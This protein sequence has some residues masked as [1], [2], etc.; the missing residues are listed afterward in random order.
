MTSQQ[1]DNLS[2]IPSS[3]VGSED[4]DSA[5]FSSGDVQ[6]QVVEF[7][8]VPD[9]RYANG[10]DLKD[11]IELLYLVDDDIISGK[12][13]LHPWQVQF[14]LD[15]AD[16]R[17]TKDHPFAA[18]VCAAN[19]SGKDKYI[20]AVCIV[21]LCMRYTQAYGVATNGSGQQLDQQTEFHIRNFCEKVNTK[22]GFA[23]WKC[24]YRA[25]KCN[26]TKSQITLFATD[27]PA[28]AEGYHPIE[29]GTKLAIFA[30]EAKSIPDDIFSALARCTGVTHRV[31][32]SSPGLP[33]GYF[34]NQWTMAVDRSAFKDIKDC[35]PAERVKWTITAMD[36]PHITEIQIEIFAK[37]EAAHGG[38]NSPIFKSGVL[39]QF[40]TQGESTVISYTHIHR[41]KSRPPT[42][43]Q[44]TYSHGGLD[45]S[46]G[47]PS[48]SVLKVRNGNKI[49]GTD[50]F[51][52]EDTEDNLDYCEELFYKYELDN[53]ESLIWGD[54]CGAG[55]P[56]LCSLRK[57]GWDNIRFFDSRAASRKPKAYKNIVTEMWFSASLLFQR[58]ELILDGD[59]QTETQLCTRYYK[60]LPSLQRQLLSKLEQLNKGYPSPDRADAL[61]YSL[62]NYKTPWKERVPTDEHRPVK[63]EPT[64]KPQSRFHQR[65]LVNQKEKGTINDRLGPRP[66]RTLLQMQIDEVN[67]QNRHNITSKAERD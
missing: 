12:V 18:E 3:S 25:Y 61:I 49:I 59:M 53:P 15:F 45:L 37:E 67:R 17:N 26:V 31:D 56:Q 35:P 66:E 46:S 51:N 39:A 11:P 58:G 6:S 54:C 24:N 63:R 20:L 16:G 27:E 13:S 9:D 4:G 55:Y 2:S 8:S 36:C 48:E 5:T 64:K 10:F 62:V 1:P 22:L 7:P 42:W 52:F 33:A 43:Q 65:M 19:G 32:V 60:T 57:R 38:R 50:A 29:A 40:C 44:E 14:M 23:I 47:G 28:K 34:F 41:C 21:W 30:S